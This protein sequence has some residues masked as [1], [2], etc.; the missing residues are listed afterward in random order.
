MLSTLN[1]IKKGLDI[2][3]KNCEILI[4]QI[5]RFGVVGG[6]AFVIDAGILFI[7]TEYFGID[8]LISNM[9]SFTASVIFN[10]IL[11]ITWVFDVRGNRKK[12]K[13]LF[14]FMFLSIIGLGINQFLMWFFAK[15]LG[16]YYMISKVIATFVVMIYN[17]ISRKIYIE[18]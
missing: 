16:I 15:F 6:S 5:L 1:Y 4:K 3:M 12:G 14:I 9:L 11:S 13:D 7:L 10:Y 17:F 18:G 2:I 8:L